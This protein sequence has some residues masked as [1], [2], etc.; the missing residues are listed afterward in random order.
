M[1]ELSLLLFAAKLGPPLSDLFP[2]SVPGDSII[3]YQHTLVYR[4][5]RNE[6]N[7]HNTVGHGTTI[8]AHILLGSSTYFNLSLSI[9]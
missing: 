8:T 2:L 3:S 1:C 9:L 5:K 4:I 7:M 6:N